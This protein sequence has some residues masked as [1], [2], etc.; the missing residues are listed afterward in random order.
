MPDGSNLAA[1]TEREIAYQ[2]R[3]RSRFVANT[4]SWYRGE[5]HLAFTILVSLGTFVFCWTKIQGATTWEW[6]MIVPIFLFGNW[7]EWAGHRYL[8]HRPVKPLKAIY[9][10]H[11]GVHH[12]FFT[13]HDL[14]YQ[15]HK[16]WRALL[17]PPF[18]PIMFLLAA[19]PAALIVGALWSANAGYIMMMT[20]AGYYLMY[21]AMHTLSHLDD[22]RHPYLK[23]VPFI[24][25]IRRMHRVHHDLGFM[26]TRNFN[27]TFPICDALFGTSDVNRGVIGTLLFGHRTDRMRSLAPDQPPGDVGEAAEATKST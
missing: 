7:C 4:P 22:V 15:G 9:L 21:E 6:L 26:Q 8:L 27:L 16:E 19:L 17:F 18:A 3:F 20:M 25:T 5:Y 14:T 1:R 10:R 12:Q 11:A 13:N 2:K 23:H 24:N